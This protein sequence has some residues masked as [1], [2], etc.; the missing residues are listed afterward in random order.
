HD[1]SKLTRAQVQLSDGEQGLASGSAGMLAYYR[2][3]GTSSYV[4]VMRL[5][6]ILD[7]R[8]GS[9]VL[10]G[11]GTFDGTTASG[12]MTVVTGSGTGGLAGITGTCESVSTHAD[13]PFM[14]LTLAYELA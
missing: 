8:A 1:G 9:F 13:Y 4:T 7:G 6:G 11:D 5:T 14:P 12:R 10:R 2:P 3:D